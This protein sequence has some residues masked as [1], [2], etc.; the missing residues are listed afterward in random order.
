MTSRPATIVVGGCQECP[1]AGPRARIAVSPAGNRHIVR[2]FDRL[3]VLATDWV[4]PLPP[5]GPLSFVVQW[6]AQG[7]LLTRAGVEAVGIVQAAAQDER[8]WPEGP[9]DA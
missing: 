1:S 9:G 3:E 5:D 7:V 6:P 4:W 8:L 2:T